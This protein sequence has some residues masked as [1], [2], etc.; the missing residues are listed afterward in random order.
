[1]AWKLIQTKLFTRN[2]NVRIYDFAAD[3]LR[4]C[5]WNIL[6]Q[7]VHHF[8][9]Q[10]NSAYSS[11]NNVMFNEHASSLITEELLL[12]LLLLLIDMRHFYSLN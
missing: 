12:E 2:Y 8:V 5:I 3:D 4:S 1:M 6:D 7:L 11:Q 9:T 10:I